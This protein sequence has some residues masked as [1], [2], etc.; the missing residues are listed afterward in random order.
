[1]VEELLDVLHIFINGEKGFL[2]G[3]SGEKNGCISSFD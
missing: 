3:S 1:M 2:L